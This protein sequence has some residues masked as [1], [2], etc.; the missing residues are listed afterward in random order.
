[1]STKIASRLRGCPSATI[2]S[3]SHSAL[4]LDLDQ[5]LA[6]WRSSPVARLP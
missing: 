3:R 5:W 1:M 4:G 2:R 6:P